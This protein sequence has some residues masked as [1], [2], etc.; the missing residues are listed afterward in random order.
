MSRFRSAEEDLGLQDGSLPGPFPPGPLTSRSSNVS[1]DEFR[2]V[3]LPGQQL[4][5]ASQAPDSQVEGTAVEMQSLEEAGGHS[6]LQGDVEII[7]PLNK[8]DVAALILNKMVGAGIYTAP[9]TVLLLTGSKAEA[10][11]LWI[12]GFLYTM[13]RYGHAAIFDVLD[14]FSDLS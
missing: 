4:S 14:E 8:W 6:P 12:L 5:Q 9:P 2:P 3:T 13:I 1:P 11:V 10:L 7:R